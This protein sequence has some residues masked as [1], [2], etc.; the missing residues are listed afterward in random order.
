MRLIVAPKQCR[1]PDGRQW[2]WSVQLYAARSGASWGI[3]D[4]AD[5]RRL[6][7]WSRKLDARVLM[8]NP[9]TAATPAPPLEASLYYPSSR[10][11]RNPLYVR[12]E[13]APGAQAQRRRR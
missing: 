9:L 8:V 13:E 4:L 1:V 11:F 10:R 3:G 12:L 7:A 2:G 5:L 6:T